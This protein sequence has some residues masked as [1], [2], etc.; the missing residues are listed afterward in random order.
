MDKYERDN[1][2]KQQLLI[3]QNIELSTMEAEIFEANKESFEKL[4]F[5]IELFGGNTFIVHA[6]PSSIANENIENVLLN[7]LGDISED[8]KT[9]AVKSPQERLIEYMAC[10]SAIKF[11]KDLSIDE[12]SSLI[13]QLDKL[14]RPYTC[15]HGRPSMV[16]LTFDELEKRF[17]RK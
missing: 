17:K 12:M 13:R 10:R 2:E 14:K 1:P 4:G 5:E 8:K 11:G 15:P 9:R 7:V 6:V 16:K 3:P